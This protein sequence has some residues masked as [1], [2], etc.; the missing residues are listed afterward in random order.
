[1]PPISGRLFENEVFVSARRWVYRFGA[2]QN[3]LSQGPERLGEN[4]SK[5]FLVLSRHRA[6]ARVALQHCPILSPDNA[7]CW[8]PTEKVNQPKT[9][10]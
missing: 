10:L 4:S 1:M 8:Q 2:G 7:D 5:T 9:C 6:S 3:L